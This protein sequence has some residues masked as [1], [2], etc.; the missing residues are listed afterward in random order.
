[1]TSYQDS[2]ILETPK[3]CVCGHK[4]WAEQRK[5][6]VGPG[7]RWRVYCTH[8]HIATDWVPSLWEASRDWDAGKV[9]R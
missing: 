3:A 2:K 1:M 7:H 6:Q 5:A 9:K 8:C 4:A